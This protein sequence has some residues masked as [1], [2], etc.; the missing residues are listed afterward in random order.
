MSTETTPA[1]VTFICDACGQFIAPREQASFGLAWKEARSEGWRS[2][3]E[4]WGKW[5]HTCPE[6]DDA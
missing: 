2:H 4:S 5:Q 6:C 3:Q 1:G